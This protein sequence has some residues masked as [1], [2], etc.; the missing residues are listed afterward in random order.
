MRDLYGLQALA[1]VAGLGL[2]TACVT[3]PYTGEQKISKTATGAAIGG[4]A[5]AAIGAASGGDRGKRAAIGAGAGVLAGGA[6]GAY[7][8]YQ[9][10]KLRE[11]L[12][13][14]GVSVTRA[15][16][17]LILN[18]PGN[19]TFE[20]NQADIRASFYDVLNSVVLVVK[21]FD[22]TIIEISG[23]TDSTGSDSYNQSLSERRADS[24][25]NYFRAFL[26]NSAIPDAIASEIAEEVRSQHRA[27][28]IWRIPM[29]GA[30]ETLSELRSRGVRTAVVSNAD[31]RAEAGLRSAGIADHVEF[32]VDS[33]YEGVEKPD[34]EIFHRALRRLDVP[35]RSAVYIGDIYSIDAVGSRA[36]GLSPVII[37]PTGTYTGLDCPVISSL[38]ELIESAGQEEST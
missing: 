7:M 19:I 25:G 21:E 24:V 8:D 31:G 3:D 36:A 35:A 14:T 22:K 26:E 32:V 29:P 2:L 28:N 17:E 23:Y 10:S 30:V 18:M 38:R 15:G 20:V 4:A 16:D 27:E 1:V 9:E 33:H 12:Q 5:G 34:P 37:D 6:V 11:Q 13:G